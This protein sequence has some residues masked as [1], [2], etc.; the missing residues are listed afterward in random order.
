[1]SCNI[2][3]RRQMAAAAQADLARTRT[4][5]DQNQTRT[6]AATSLQTPM[7]KMLAER[8]KQDQMWLSGQDGKSPSVHVAATERYG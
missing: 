4:Q 5:V 2:Q 7:Q 8:E 3:K 6:Q 1:M